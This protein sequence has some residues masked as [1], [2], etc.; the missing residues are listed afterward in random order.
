M[1][2]LDDYHFL[3]VILGA[4]QL[5][6]HPQLMPHSIH[7][8]AV[9]EKFKDDYFYLECIAFINKVKKVRDGSDPST[10]NFL[11]LCLQYISIACTHARAR[12]ILH[13]RV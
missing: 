5:V 6:S 10:F 1:W 4:S 8:Q 13:T 9:I 7:D 3:P 2:G 11:L 12:I